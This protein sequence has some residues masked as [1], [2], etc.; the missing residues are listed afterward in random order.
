LLHAED[1][2]TAVHSSHTRRPALSGYCRNIF[3]NP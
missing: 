3:T 2:L 1:R